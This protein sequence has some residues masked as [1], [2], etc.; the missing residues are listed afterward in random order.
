MCYN[1]LMKNRRF[2][3]IELPYPWYN[4]TNVIKAGESAFYLGVKFY[5]NPYA[6][7]PFHSWWIRGFKR[8]ERSHF[9]AVKFSQQV[10][11]SIGVEEVE[12]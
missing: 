4:E 7:N 2:K 9:E 3:K 5:N 1:N 11:E 8:A 12:V 10:Q 6:N